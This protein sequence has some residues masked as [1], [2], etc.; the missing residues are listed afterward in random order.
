[1][2]DAISSGIQATFT[3]LSSG[4]VNNCKV[5]CGGS[6]FWNQ[7]QMFLQVEAMWDC[8]SIWDPL[9][10]QTSATAPNTR[11]YVT[12]TWNSAAYPAKPLL[13]AGLSSVPTTRDESD[14]SSVITWGTASPREWKHGVTFN[15][16]AG[17]T[18][19]VDV[20]R[21]RI[22]ANRATFL[23][24]IGI[25]QSPDVFVTYPI[26]SINSTASSSS[27]LTTMSF[28]PGFGAY[29]DEIFEEYLEHTVLSGL[30]ATGGL[31]SAFEVIFILIFGR[32]LLAA[33][34]GGKHV[35]PFG[36]IA[37][38]LKRES[39]RERLLIEYPGIDG[40]D[41]AQRAHA[42]C[43][44]LHDFVLDLKP[45]EIPYT[46]TSQGSS[47]DSN[48]TKPGAGGNDG[49]VDIDVTEKTA[50]NLPYAHKNSVDDSV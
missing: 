45:L 39:F 29:D 10:Y 35:T 48:Q 18:L 22:Y 25:S 8:G 21:R 15:F 42:T 40:N 50:P 47:K 36:A 4:Q 5:E 17:Q 44:F 34:F 20:G 12:V 6:D 16:T 24:L 32:S 3:N 14:Y 49:K 31:Y 33:L 7:Y 41:P 38:M 37:S 23:D 19:G 1:M 13:N 27:Q 46:D 26:L 11:P 9:D 28:Y 30:S 2:C 43:K